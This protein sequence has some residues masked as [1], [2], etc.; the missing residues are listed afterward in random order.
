MPPPSN[1]TP[2][3]KRLKVLKQPK[4]L[5]DQVYDVILQA[6]SD[7]TIA[8]GERVTQE[9]IATRLNVSRQPV[10]HALAILK[11][12]GFFIATSK[13]GLIV[14][15]VD[16]RHVADIYQLRSTLEPLAVTLATPRMTPERYNVGRKIIERG[17]A[18]V[19]SGNIANALRVDVEFHQFIYELSGNPLIAETM[20]LHWVHL[21]RG[22]TKTLQQP[23]TP[24]AVWQEHEQI[25]EAMATGDPEKSSALMR[26]HLAD[27]HSRREGPPS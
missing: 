15:A 14:T 19:S 3:R 20:R 9:L 4:N 13:R 24:F 22:M 11:T 5:V 6:L 26:N 8:A 1:T 23:G 25:L 21:C 12:Q 17:R 10:T 18:S 27:A 2:G 16:S 7:G